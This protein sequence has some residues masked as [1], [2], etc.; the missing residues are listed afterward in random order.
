MSVRIGVMMFC[1]ALGAAPASAQRL[2]TTVRPDHYDLRFIVDI[3][4]A[5]FDGTETIKVQVAEATN[6]IVL[7]AVDI[8]FR[9]VTVGSGAEAQP[10][11]V[12][13]DDTKQQATLSVAR[14]LS[15]GVTEIHIQYSG[16]L[17]DQLRG[18]YRSKGRNRDYA[19]T[20]FESTDARRAFP[21]FDE[22][23]F[24]A[25]FAI[26]L[27][28]DRGDRAISNGSV[29]SN[30]AGP[31]PT[32]H[33]T[34]FATTPK[35][36]PYLVAIAVGDF[37]CAEGSADNIPIRICATPDKKD[38][39]RIALESAQQIMHFYNTWYAIKY[40][41]GKLDVVAVPD[42]AAGAMENTAAIFYRETD[43]LADSKSASVT[44][45]KTIAS[46]L[47]HEMAHQWFGDLVTMAWWDDIWLNEGFATWMANK[48]LAALHPEWNIA[49]DEATETQTA[50]NLDSLRSTRPIHDDA[51]KPGA[52]DELFD[53][54]AYEKGASV[55]R[56]IESYVGEEAFRKGV[57]A[58]LQAHAY[59]N[60][61]SEDLAKA[62]A[63]ASGKPIDRLLPTFVSQ[64]GAPL[65]AVSNLACDDQRTVTHATFRQERFLVDAPRADARARWMI[66]VCPKVQGSS[67]PPSCYPISDPESRIDV[68]RGC[69]SWIFAN[70]GARG[71]YRTEYPP[72][73]LR[74]I[75]PDVQTQLTAPER[76][77]L[78]DDEWAM[79][80]ARRHTA[81]DYLTLASGYGREHANGVLADVTN[82]LG[83]IHDYLTTTEDRPRFEGFVG[84][85]LRP[86]LGEL[87][88]APPLND[89]D[90]RRALRATVVDAL[91]SIANDPD[92][93]SQ[94]RAALD[95]A[96]AGQ[97]P[98]DPTLAESVVRVAAEHGDARLLDAL[99]AAARRAASPEEEYR[100][101]FA[102]SA[103][104][105][106]A[107][108]DRALQLALTPQ[109]RSQDAPHY[110][111]QFFDNPAA[112]GRAWTFVTTHWTEL[113][114]K[115]TIAGGDVRLVSSAGAFCDAASRDAVAA[116]FATHPLA[117]AARTLE[118]TI[119]RI[120][121]C[122]ALRETQTPVLA[123]WL[124]NR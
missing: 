94:A 45:R 105:E 17:N 99:L 124:A 10:A 70:G 111:G 62:I 24:K 91:G 77:S 87:G 75:A 95:R 117:G 54:I 108:I 37:Q 93:V 86:L 101:L 112:R 14:R 65:I 98:L 81:A 120:D 49:V 58:Y 82:R 97:T 7:N 57:N 34:T 43:L 12:T 60:A 21:C 106:P 53:A 83:F 33:T 22:P 79:V 5:R 84:Q 59:G 1:F 76:L 56:M 74:A 100:Y 2:P 89:P 50:L 32:Q 122:V 28:I 39:T 30:V 72:A 121:N 114:P 44:A 6:T 46:V 19:V 18:F 26:A 109:I 31:L 69:P 20:Q 47:A 80:R 73:L 36:S 9:D 64:A 78:V 35:M 8:R 88:F 68:A 3:P 27:T 51:E 48:P 41:F 38:L 4:R 67:S 113:A 42:F 104:R 92:V 115:I 52:I 66:P 119:E 102:L 85:L 23:A 29:I 118:Q 116:F 63:G 110:L 16:V 25:T 123:A 96:L 40:P 90:D 107:L 13:L 61:T 71:Y 11:A 103:F 55:L 15:P